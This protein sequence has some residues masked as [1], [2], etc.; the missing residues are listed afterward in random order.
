[1]LGDVTEAGSDAAYGSRSPPGYHLRSRHGAHGPDEPRE[2]DCRTD[3]QETRTDVG[4]GDALAQAPQPHHHGDHIS[5]GE[6]GEAD[7]RHPAE[8]VDHRDVEALVI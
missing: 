2:Q 6:R 8:Y 1:M 4:T 5:N 3:E 7:G